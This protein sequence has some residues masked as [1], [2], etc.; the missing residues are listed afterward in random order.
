MDVYTFW[1]TPVCW[2]RYLTFMAMLLFVSHVFLI[3][4][5]K[6]ARRAT[7]LVYRRAPRTCLRSSTTT[8]AE[9]ETKTRAWLCWR[10]LVAVSNVEEVWLV[11]LMVLYS[12]NMV[13]WHPK[14]RMYREVNHQLPMISNDDYYDIVDHTISNGYT[15][16]RVHDQIPS[17]STST[18]FPFGIQPFMIHAYQQNSKPDSNIWFKTSIDAARMLILI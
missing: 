4:A 11:W 8:A 12:G 14:Y 18:V 1:M 5:P 17:R 9:Q 10:N 13:P 3:W 6:V 7:R 15:D 16:G 2:R